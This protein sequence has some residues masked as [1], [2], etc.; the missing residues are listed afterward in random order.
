MAGWPAHLLAKK[1]VQFDNIISIPISFC[2]LKHTGIGRRNKFKYSSKEIQPVSPLEVCWK[3]RPGPQSR[4][5]AV[6]SSELSEN[7]PLP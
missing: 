2:L 1:I 4:G 5:G 7:E 6:M 3:L